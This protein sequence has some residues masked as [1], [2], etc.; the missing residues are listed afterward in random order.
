MGRKEVAVL[1]AGAPPMRQLAARLRRQGF[2]VLPSKT[3]DHAE[4]LLR[5]RGSAVAAVVI[6]VDLPTFDLGAALRFLRRLEP[7]GEL[8]FV[9][10]GHRPD[11]ED[12][13]LLRDAGIE[14]AL[15]GPVDDHTLR[16]QM[17]RALAT[18]EIVLG[19]RGR[20]RAPADWPIVVHAGSRRKPARIYSLSSGGTYLATGR[21]SL[22]GADVVVEL[23][24]PASGTR[25]P[26]RVVMTNVPGNLI[27]EN[28]PVGMGVSFRKV[29]RDV[30]ASLDAWVNDRID[31]LGF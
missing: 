29:A 8:T 18:S 12:R 15:W 11:S 5:Q 20:L 13:E 17:N 28:L 27:R 1:D 16:F 10:S 19:K 2:A 23:P 30:E 3:P 22:P 26:A 9:A 31:E 24:L 6:P 4:R 14:L 7:S 25:I 21:P